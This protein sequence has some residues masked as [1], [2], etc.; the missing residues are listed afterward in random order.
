MKTL[1]DTEP[2]VRTSSSCFYPHVDPIK[3][4]GCID[5]KY[6]FFPTKSSNNGKLHITVGIPASGKTTYIQNLSSHL[7]DS[8]IPFEVIFI[9]NIKNK[10]KNLS[11]AEITN[12]TQNQ[13]GQCL[14]SKKECIYDASNITNEQRKPFLDT[15]IQNRSD[16][17]VTVFNINP[18]IAVYRD[19][20]RGNDSVG[21]KTI[22][23]AYQK[24][25]SE[26]G[27]EDIWKERDE[28]LQHNYKYNVGIIDVELSK[29]ECNK[30]GEMN[31]LDN[32]CEI[33]TS[34]FVPVSPYN[35]NKDEWVI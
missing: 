1:L 20:R 18:E 10:N 29:N 26:E 12:I 5:Y 4:K 22:M 14:R 30:I 27:I 13:I 16:I 31:P 7:H 28:A 9:D 2:D 8:K 25:K 23:K 19:A 17:F 34:N 21:R 24:M 6:K 15:A 32:N 3:V 11:E 33:K 35:D